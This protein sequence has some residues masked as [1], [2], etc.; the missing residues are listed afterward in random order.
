M[1][2]Q[3]RYERSPE[4]YLIDTDAYPRTLLQEEH[5]APETG[6]FASYTTS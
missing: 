2:R 4:T 6:Q 3:T 1:I 5:P